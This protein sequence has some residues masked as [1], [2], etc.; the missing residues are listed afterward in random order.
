MTFKSAMSSV[1]NGLL[2]T[3]TVLHNSPVQ[4]RIS[5]INEEM[6]KLQ[7]EKTRLEDQLIR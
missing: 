2:V 7:D 3:A 6:Q 5:E 1:G 4:T